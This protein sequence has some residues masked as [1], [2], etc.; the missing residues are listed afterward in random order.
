V[1]V[2]AAVLGEILIHFLSV[3]IETNRYEDWELGQLERPIE[4]RNPA[5]MQWRGFCGGSVTLKFVG[6]RSY[7]MF[8]FFTC[9]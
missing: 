7:S 6:P 4:L 8:R 2:A 3:T 5:S 9:Q 1:W